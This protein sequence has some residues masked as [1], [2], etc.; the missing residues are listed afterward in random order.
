[1][2]PLSPTAAHAS[3]PLSSAL[4]QAW[5]I[6]CIASGLII[7]VA[8]VALAA[9]QTLAGAT[10][11]FG[12]SYYAA[13]APVPTQIVVLGAAPVGYAPVPRGYVYAVATGTAATGGG[14][15]GVEVLPAAPMLAPVGAGGA[16]KAV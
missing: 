8:S 15:V 5:I 4:L 12:A 14:T 13:S 16:P 10:Y 7:V 1:M 3:S 9:W 11:D 2:P 6:T